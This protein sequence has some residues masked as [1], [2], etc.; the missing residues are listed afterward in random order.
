MM[1]A[2]IVILGYAEPISSVAS[3]SLTRRRTRFELVTVNVIVGI[4]PK[5]VTQQHKNGNLLSIPVGHDAG[6]FERS[7]LIPVEENVTYK[8]FMG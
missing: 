1:A 8:A 6:S 7:E 3:Q 2:G 4:R 5:R